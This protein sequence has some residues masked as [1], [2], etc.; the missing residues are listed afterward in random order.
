[1]TTSVLFKVLLILIRVLP[2]EYVL[3]Y[4]SYCTEKDETVKHRDRQIVLSQVGRET[5]R[6]RDRDRKIQRDKETER[7]RESGEVRRTKIDRKTERGREMV[8]GR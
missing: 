8:M 2:E 7:Q 4:F 5:E 1:M 6:Q 3:K